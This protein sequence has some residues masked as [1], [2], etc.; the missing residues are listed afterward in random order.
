MSTSYRCQVAGCPDFLKRQAN[1]SCDVIVAPSQAEPRHLK[2][3]VTAVDTQH[4]LYSTVKKHRLL[5]DMNVTCTPPAVPGGAEGLLASMVIVGGAGQNEATVGADPSVTDVFLELRADSAS[6]SSAVSVTVGTVVSSRE[7]PGGYPPVTG[8]S[9]VQEGLLIRA[10]HQGGGL[11]QM[12]LQP[13]DAVGAPPFHY[14]LA[15]IVETQTAAGERFS[16]DAL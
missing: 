9:S 13:A 6:G 2:A 8:L 7:P 14:E 4:L 11:Y 1:P 16:R 10:V 12:A 3:A 15:L 5:T